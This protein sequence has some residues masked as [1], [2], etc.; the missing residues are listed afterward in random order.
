VTV[1][2][3]AVA[4]APQRVAKA[5]HRCQGNSAASASP[6]SS[7]FGMNAR[8]GSARA[9]AGR[10][11][12]RSWKSGRQQAVPRL[13]EPRRYF[14]PVNAGKLNIKQDKLR[15]QPLR[16]GDSGLAISGLA[17][18]L[19]PIRLKQR[20]G[21]LPEALMV[22]D[23]QDG[24]RHQISVASRTTAHTRA[25]PCPSNLVG[26]GGFEPPASCL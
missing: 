8:A 7:P 26:A 19:D 2:E 10:N 4:A 9:A 24:E 25:N 18:D 15:P 6:D 13:A 17:H 11:L 1:A 20:T 3:H 16:L 14:E 21:H 22:V 23:D 12:R 5:A